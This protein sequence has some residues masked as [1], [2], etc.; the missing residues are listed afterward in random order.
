MSPVSE[1]ATVP[2]RARA[3]RRPGD[4]IVV[5]WIVKHTSLAAFL[6]VT[7]VGFLT[8]LVV[9]LS[10]AFNHG[11][12][13]LR[14][15]FA[16][17]TFP[18]LLETTVTLALGD[19]VFSLI[20]GTALAWFAYRLPRRMRWLGFLPLV[21]LVMPPLALVLGYIF[22]AA[23]IAGY[24]NSF[25]RAILPWEHGAI[26]GPFDVYSLAWMIVIG[27]ISLT[28]FVF[29]F[30]QSAL[31]QVPGEVIDGAA[32][33]GAGPV[34]TYWKVVLPLI[35]PGLVYGAFTVFLLGF[36]EFTIPLLLGTTN[37]IYVLTSALYKQLNNYPVNI[38]LASAYGLPVVLA[39]LLLI[40]VQRFS[41]RQQERFSAGS[42]RGSRP[43]STNGP[44][45]QV[46][47]GLYGFIGVLLPL[48]AIV[49]VSLE[50]NWSSTISASN[51]TLGNYHYV[52][53]S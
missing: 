17:G 20:A 2:L 28:A 38:A 24:A 37:S 50:K 22:L 39:G 46:M 3:A 25:L 48:F 29:L 40:I 36:G 10:S 35:R 5:A 19:A 49:V 51:F 43:L 7:V 14:Q 23:P 32:A 11:A 44:I 12:S 31:S 45:A 18:K 8:P 53:T 15:M 26:S 34:R 27:S 6:L 41:L 30:V 1:R 47:L 52:L 16:A 33:S 42:G 13:G 21:P 9:V 4:S